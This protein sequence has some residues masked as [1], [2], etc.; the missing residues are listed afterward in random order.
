MAFLKES[1]LGSRPKAANH[2]SRR[3]SFRRRPVL[4]AL[5]R[6]PFTPFTPFTPL[7]ALDGGRIAYYQSTD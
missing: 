2:H 7:T 3:L 4:H 5:S 1:D 6:T